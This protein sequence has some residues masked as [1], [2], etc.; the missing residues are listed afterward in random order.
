MSKFR[1]LSLFLLKKNK[2]YEI[3]DEIGVLV[4]DLHLIKTLPENSVFVRVRCHEEGEK[5]SDVKALGPPPVDKANNSNRMSPA[6]IPMFYGSIDQETALAETYD[7]R[8]YATIAKFKTLK[9]FKVLDLTELAS[10]PSLFDNELRW[11]RPGIIFLHSFLEDFT[12]PIERDGREHI[13]YVPTQIVTE[14]FRRIFLDEEGDPIKGIIYPSAREIGGKSC[15][16]FF[17]SE[18]CIQD[19]VDPENKQDKWLSMLS[20][21]KKTIKLP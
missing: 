14:F 10:I 21:S 9:S 17:Q 8:P 1:R 7:K 2:P 19:N 20:K 16:L 3:L 13:E 6:G 4:N 18:D 11:L 15:V 5:L 12:K